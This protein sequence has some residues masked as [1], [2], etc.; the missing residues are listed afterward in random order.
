MRGLYAARVTGR[1]QEDVVDELT[2]RGFVY[3]RR[4]YVASSV[5]VFFHSFSLLLQPQGSVL[6]DGDGNRFVGGNEAGV[7]EMAEVRNWE[8]FPRRI[9]LTFLAYFIFVFF[10]R[11]WRRLV[12]FGSIQYT[13]LHTHKIT[14]AHLYTRHY[15]SNISLTS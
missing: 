5:S 1:L 2:S 14:H 15:V 8:R 4:E 3:R 10:Q 12:A 6:L 9:M 13:H 7:G 11:A